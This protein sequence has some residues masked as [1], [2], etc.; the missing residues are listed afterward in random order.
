[1]YFYL[2]TCYGSKWREF[3][4]QTLIIQAIIQILHIKID[5]LI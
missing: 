1:M 5:T 2:S 4:T 3:F